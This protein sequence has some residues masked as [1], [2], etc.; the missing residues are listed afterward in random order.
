MQGP[1]A[2]IRFAIESTM[3]L[4]APAG[5]LAPRRE[6]KLRLAA[7]ALVGSAYHRL[8]VPFQWTPLFSVPFALLGAWLHYN[9]LLWAGVV[10]S[11]L[12][13]TL[14]IADGVATGLSVNHLPASARPER[15]IA[16]R[17]F[18][19]TFVADPIAHLSL[20][21]VFLL[22][23]RKVA[24]VPDPLL[25]L[26][27]AIESLNVVLGGLSEC[28]G[29]RDEFFYEFVLEKQARRRYSPFYR[30][31][32]IGGHLSAYYVYSLFP[33]LGYLAP[34]S[35]CGAVYFFTLLGLRGLVLGARLAS[36]AGAR[37]AHSAE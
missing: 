16:L 27:A 17:R 24:V 19:D 11:L 7:G 8:G 28:S 14:D 12:V 21:G 3:Q 29:R 18:L 2:S 5:A 25:M 20:Y 35:S 36:L 32:V 15:S 9:G 26:M 22:L 6:L 34:I 33:L 1:T 10:C 13:W 30:L 37:Q 23:L 31:R 4:T